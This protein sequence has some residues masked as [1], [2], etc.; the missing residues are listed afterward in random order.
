M[1]LE[2]HNSVSLGSPLFDCISVSA[3]RINKPLSSFGTSKKLINDSFDTS[4][5]VQLEKERE[6]LSWCADHLNGREGI[7]AF[8]EKRKPV[9]SG[10]T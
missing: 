9:F 10:A 8:L 5:E 1:I 2:W 4:F 6:A 3:G 7:T